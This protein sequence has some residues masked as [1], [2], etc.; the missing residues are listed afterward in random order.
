MSNIPKFIEGSK[1][2][3]KPFDEAGEPTLI[4]SVLATLLPNEPLQKE[5]MLAKIGEQHTG[6][7]RGY[8][9][10]HFTELS[11]SGIIKFRKIDR[12]WS[13]GENYLMYMGFVFMEMIEG[14]EQ[15]VDSLKYK[16][17]P[18]RDAQSIDF[19]TSPEEDIFSKPNPY[20]TPKEKM[21]PLMDA[22]EESSIVEK[23]S[24]RTTADS[25]LS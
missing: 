5:A 11:K 14:N 19:M 3:R 2:L 22:I 7:S 4:T 12:T 18:K 23:K 21:Q 25:Y 16:L 8:L 13:Q 15:A 9:S 10:N 17:M 20:L 6:K 24:K 1:T